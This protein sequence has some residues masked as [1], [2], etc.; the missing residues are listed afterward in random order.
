MSWINRNLKWDK[1][2]LVH[3][4]ENEGREMTNWC[5]RSN[6]KDVAD[7]LSSDMLMNFR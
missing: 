4:K 7:K 5:M 3:T 2:F 6:I 1:I